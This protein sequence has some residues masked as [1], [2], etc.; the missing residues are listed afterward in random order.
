MTPQ[1]H[2]SVDLEDG[3]VPGLVLRTGRDGD[4]LLVTYEQQGHVVTSW[5]DRGVVRPA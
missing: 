5:L 3:T 2:V 4:L 1:S